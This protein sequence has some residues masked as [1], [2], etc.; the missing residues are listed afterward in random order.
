MSKMY[1]SEEHRNAYEK[2][3][4][5][6]SYST[7]VREFIGDIVLCNKVMELDEYLFDNI[8]VGD[9]NEIPDIFQA[10]ICDVTD[11]NIHELRELQCEDII[12]AYSNLLETHVLLVTHFGTSWNYVSTDVELTDEF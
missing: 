7:L 1:L 5:R 3:T 9:F 2:E 6:A 8:V 4:G 11:W 12:I 10:Y